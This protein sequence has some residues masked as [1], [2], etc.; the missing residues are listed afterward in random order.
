MN[1]QTL[2]RSSS[3][4]GSMHYTDGG[5]PLSISWS[6]EQEVRNMVQLSSRAA[7]NNKINLS[8]TSKNHNI[9]GIILLITYLLLFWKISYVIPVSEKIALQSLL[10]AT[11]A[12]PSGDFLVPS[13]LWSFK[14]T[15]A[16]N[17]NVTVTL[18]PNKVG[19]LWLWLLPVEHATVKLLY[20]FDHHRRTVLGD[21]YM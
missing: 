7:N 2:R 1:T 17:G 14:F 18:S 11:H 6:S 16:V 19:C 15:S 3:S 10:R 8:D 21:R 13:K 5:R 9:Y 20:K 4:V 12:I